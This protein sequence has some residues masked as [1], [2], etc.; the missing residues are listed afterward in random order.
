MGQR[1][2]SLSSYW[3]LVRDNRNFRLLWTAQIVSELG[4][5]LYSI[6]IYS[7]LLELTG[8]ATAVALAV[9]LQVLPQFFIAPAAGVLNDRISRKR[10]M[11]LADLARA[12]IALGMLVGIRGG[13]VWH[14]YVLLIAETVMWAFFE[15]AR[16][17]VI[18]NITHGD[19]VL[20]ANTLSSTTWSIN[21]AIGAAVGGAVAVIFGRDTVFLINALSF[22]GSALSIRAMKFSEP[23]LAEQV[24][25]TAKD[26]TDFSPLIEGIRYILRERRLLATLLVKAGLG[27]LGANW[28]IL[29]IFGERIFPVHLSGLDSSRAGML[30]MSIL[31]GARG[32]GSLLGPLA[33]T[34]WAGQ[35]EAK[36]RQGIFYGFLA[37]AVGYVGLGGAPSLGVAL[38]AVILGHAGGSIIWVFSTTLLQ[39]HTDDRFRGRVFSADYACLV[40][41]NSV[42]SYCVGVLIDFGISVKLLAI[43]TGLFGLGP[44]MAWAMAQRLWRPHSD[45]SVSNHRDS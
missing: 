16:N 31:V 44:A 28:V 10:I 9:V 22:A 17:A 24:P 26:L 8:R 39:V 6:T 35:N 27:L 1:F 5:W 20:V 33:S 15:P 30:G 14:I 21:L 34:Y 4:D 11:I 3:R 19:E 43:L 23:H 32:I 13:L 7:L 38:A 41:T 2:V 37:A 18:P 12:G 40:L 29:P 42:V 25:L 45:N 36:L